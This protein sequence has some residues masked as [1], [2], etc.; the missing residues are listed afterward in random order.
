MNI[1][2][3]RSYRQ[4]S[5]LLNPWE[6]EAIGE[7]SENSLCLSVS[8]LPVGR[9][10]SGTSLAIQWLRLHLPMQGGVQVQ[11]LVG[12][13]E[14]H[15]PLGQKTKT[16]KQKKYCNKLNKDFKNGL[17][18]KKKKKK[19]RWMSELAGSMYV[20]RLGG[21]LCTSP[22]PSP[23]STSPPHKSQQ[24]NKGRTEQ[25]PSSGKN[26]NLGWLLTKPM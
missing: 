10:M 16:Q 22:A 15:V 5:E 26:S 2:S 13:L 18:P 11:F 25:G 17:H 19:K 12:E 23:T 6:G 7:I 8:H 3:A 20:C 9:W 24:N 4:A 1:S 14:F 21:L